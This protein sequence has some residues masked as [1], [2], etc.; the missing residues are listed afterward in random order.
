MLIPTQQ[1]RNTYNIENKGQIFTLRHQIGCC[2]NKNCLF[3]SRI[4]NVKRKQQPD[5]NMLRNE[6]IRTKYEAEVTSAME[7]KPS[8][9]DNMSSALKNLQ[10]SVLQAAKKVLPT[11]KPTP[12]RKRCVSEKTKQL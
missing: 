10:T 1:H 3:K 12:L 7:K 2:L 9:E 11:R 4:K 6:D 5:Y 8:G